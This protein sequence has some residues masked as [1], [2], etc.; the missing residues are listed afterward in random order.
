MIYLWYITDRKG[1]SDVLRTNP[2]TM[3]RSD[4]RYRLNL[5]VAKR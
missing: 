5:Q 4:A 1:E 2:G 3:L